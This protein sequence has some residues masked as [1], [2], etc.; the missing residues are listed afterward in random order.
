MNEKKLTKYFPKN[1]TSEDMEKVIESLLEKW[2]QE[3]DDEN[4]IGL[5]EK[6]R[7]GFG[8]A[9]IIYVKSFMVYGRQGEQSAEE[10]QKFTKQTNA[11]NLEDAEVYKTNSLKSQKQTS[12]SPE[13]KTQEVCNSNSNYNNTTTL[14][15][16][17]C[18]LSSF[19]NLSMRTIRAKSPSCSLSSRQINL[20][21]GQLAT[22]NIK[23]VVR[24]KL[25]DSRGCTTAIFIDHL[26][27]FSFEQ[28]LLRPP[29]GKEPHEE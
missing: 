4:G 11:D 22:I 24:R 29:Y 20:I 17:R 3:L 2:K 1:Y 21:Y 23:A 25:A 15:T 8:K 5:I 10:T 7:Q 26:L 28:V 14:R 16:S 18:I 13:N 12:R 19:F 9:N 27:I 6:R